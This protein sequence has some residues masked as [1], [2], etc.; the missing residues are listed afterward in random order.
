LPHVRLGIGVE[1]PHPPM[2]KEEPPDAL[3]LDEQRVQAPVDEVSLAVRLAVQR[4]IYRVH[5]PSWL[6]GRNPFPEDARYR[7]PDKL[8]FKGHRGSDFAPNLLGALRAEGDSPSTQR[9]REHELPCL[10]GPE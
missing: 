10:A 9:V 6:I 8:A 2:V 1:R 4:L 7:P 5:L 3:N